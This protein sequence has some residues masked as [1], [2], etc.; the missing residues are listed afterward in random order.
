MQ[1]C[2][3]D[4]SSGL[5]DMNIQRAFVYSFALA[6]FLAASVAPLY[7]AEL[8]GTVV[9]PAQRPIAGATVAAVNDV[10]I[11]V[12]Q[13]TDD[14]GGFDFNVSPL[15]ETFQLRV[16]APGFQT[17]TVGAGASNIQLALAP[18]SDSVSVVGSAIDVAASQ[19]GTSS[20]VI[21]SGEIRERNEAQAFDLMRELPGMVFAQSGPRGSVADLFVRGGTSSYNLVLL[22]GIPINSFYYGGYFDFSQIPSDFI[23]EIDVARG[24]QSAIYGSYAIGS[25]VNFVTR[26]PENGPSLDVLAEGGTHDENRVSVSGSDML[27]GWGV[28]GS[29]SSLL[30]NGPVRNGDYRNDNIFL[31][32]EHRWYTQNLFT[33]GDFDSNNVGEPG[34]FGSNPQGL[35]PGIDLISRSKN[36]TSTYGA[37]YQNDLTDTV[38]LDLMTGFFLNN[39]FYISPYADSFNKDIRGYGEARGTW[40]ATSFWTLA[41]GFVFEREELKNTYIASTNGYVFPFRRDH[42]GVYLENRLTFIKKLFLNAG[43]REEVYETPFIPGDAYVY[44]NGRPNFPARTDSRLNPKISGAYMLQPTVRLHASYGTGIR[45]PGGSDLA[46]TNNPALAPER[47][48]SYDIGVEERFLSGRLSLDATWFHNRYKDLIVSLGGSLSEISQYQTGNLANSLSKGV[49]ASARFRPKSWISL[50][51]N[52]MWL[53]SAVLSLTGSSTLVQEYFYLGQPLLRQP[54]QSGSA[55]VNFQYKRLSVNLVGYFRGHDLDVEPNFGASEGL[56]WSAGYVNTGIN[57]NYRVRGNLTAYAN[58]RN[59]LDRRYEE[60]Y[61]FP[62][63]L[64]NVVAGLKWSLARAR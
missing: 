34:P 61:G 23:S 29:L 22:D 15:Y 35:Y 4:G 52:Y 45:P 1:E 27:H 25:V 2:G 37:H 30:T 21:T 47:T 18:Q 7:S 38:R 43:L 55:V 44:P 17:V 26:A 49:E 12:E 48:E 53:E 57:V 40:K 14:G 56:Y 62:A 24:P 13:I 19:Q 20:S 51:G 10:G 60:V 9:D 63:P 39:S 59:A 42:E 33:F 54:K 5:P 41:G 28:A 32:L 3:K 11:I 31:S 36:N 6:A 16:T 64:L 46:F 58:L 50:T 8:K